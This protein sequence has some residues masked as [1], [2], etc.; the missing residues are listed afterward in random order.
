MCFAVFQDH[1][2]LFICIL[3]SEEMFAFTVTEHDFLLPLVS[4]QY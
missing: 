2:Y 3:C 1:K 4:F